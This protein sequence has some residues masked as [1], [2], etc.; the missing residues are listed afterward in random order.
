ML[1]PCHKCSKI[2][3]NP[4]DLINHLKTVH[5][6]R[7]HWY[8]C[9][10][11]NSTFDQLYKFR[12]HTERCFKKKA[13]RD[14]TQNV[15]LQKLNEDHQIYEELTTD[16]ALD[17]GCKLAANM[18]V[19]RNSVFEVIND[20]KRFLCSIVEGMQSLV[21]PWVKEE[22]VID[23]KNIISIMGESLE[24]VS[25]EYQLNKCLLEKKL[26]SSVRKVKIG[27]RTV[28]PL[29]HS[30]SDDED[31]GEVS[32]Q[33]TVSLMPINFQ[34]KSFFELPHVFEKLQSNT[35]N[36]KKDGR[37]N[38][39]INGKLWKSKLQH[40]SKDDVVIPYH[41]HIDDTQTNNPLGTHTTNGDQTCVYYSFPTMPNE[42]SS[43][44]ENIFTA[45][46]FESRLSLDFGND[47][48]Y[49]E[50]IKELN[51]MADDGIVLNINGKEQKVY[52]VL[53][54][55]LGDNKGVNHCLGYTKGFKA[56]HYCRFCRMCRSK[57]QFRYVEDANY[58]RN[59]E[60]YYQDL[61]I[62][63]MSETG[64]SENS[65]FNNVRYF[66]ATQTCADVM[67][68]VDEGILH[69][70]LC[71]VIHYFIENEY[72]TLEMLNQAKTDI[73][74]GEHEENNRTTK[75]IT[76]ENLKLKK[77]KMTAS[78]AHSFAHHLPFILLNIIHEDA[79]D[80]LESNEV[81]RF[82]L[83]TL[84]FLDMSYMTCYDTE[85][86]HTLRNVVAT[87]NEMYV[88]LFKQ[89]LKP[90]HHFATHYPSLIEALGPLRYMSSMRYEANHKFVKNYTK[91][92][93]SRR[94]ISYSLGL[95]LQY[96]FAYLLKKGNVCK[97]ILEISQPKLTKIF[98]EDFY[99]S[100]VPSN[101]LELLSQRYI[102]VSEKIKFNG[103]TL[104][105]KLHL[106]FIDGNRIHLLQIVKLIM[107]SKDDPTSIRVM[108]KKFVDVQYESVYASY[109]ATNLQPQIHIVTLSDVLRNRIFPVA[110]HRVNGLNIFR[111][112]TF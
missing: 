61:A 55:L 73:K 30:D 43:R 10:L 91:N 69:Y 23:F 44:L 105:S 108:C 66:H 86:I 77:L 21:I 11:C 34:I 89:T 106:P 72:F 53:G 37:L 76:I 5:Q 50:L 85:T 101:E 58:I 110:L 64:I 83:V 63:K 13:K 45:L 2:T 47:Q 80:H 60:N 29:M 93:T 102:Y 82:L 51:K 32:K 38:H 40:F 17:F 94:N 33:E 31:D 109:N 111:Y 99:Q 79:R 100:I 7:N 57:M 107:V 78:E 84:R 15:F 6:I 52:F 46:V 112:K 19:P 88:R 22:N 68:D 56:N 59:I 97:D 12:Q 39:F 103:L 24:S 26:I 3:S 87:M 9:S 48:C 92:T 16:A 42:Y 41:L 104:S 67:H 96:N 95:K 36:I 71:E 4:T 35:E 81:W 62:G 74:Y 18:N 70:N 75:N 14:S 98:D 25:T 27:E 28:D 1:L 90:K 8:T 54:L 49:D 20:T 65:V